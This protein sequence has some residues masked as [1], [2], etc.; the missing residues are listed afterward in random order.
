MNPTSA[1]VP[2]IFLTI[3]VF[4]KRYKVIIKEKN[5]VGCIGRY[6]V[7]VYNMKE[8][9]GNHIDEVVMVLAETTNFVSR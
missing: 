2:F 9:V 3:L 5:V 4:P 6:K 7:V 1:F 8:Q